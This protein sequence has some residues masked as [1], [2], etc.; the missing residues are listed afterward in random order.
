MSK[1]YRTYSPE[2]KSKV[3]KELLKQ[4]KTIAELASEH[5]VTVKTIQSWHQQFLDNIDTV[6]KSNKVEKEHKKELQEKEKEIEA[7]HKEIGSLVTQ[8]SWLK[9]KCKQVGLEH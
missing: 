6:F 5:Q 8:L 1:K 9:K 3:V 2:F 4:D 7:A